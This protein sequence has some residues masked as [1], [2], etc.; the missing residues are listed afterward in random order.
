MFEADC[1]QKCSGL[2]NFLTCSWGV[3]SPSGSGLGYVTCF[4]QCNISKCDRRKDLKRNCAF[5][6]FPFAAVENSV[7][8]T[9]CASPTATVPAA[10]TL[11]KKEKQ[12]HNPIQPQPK[13]P[14]PEGQP[15]QS[16]S[17]E[18]INECCFKL[19][20]FGVFCY[21]AWANW[22][23]GYPASGSLQSALYK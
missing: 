16:E 9:M 11:N 21:V 12:F 17:W 7:T 19:L 5:G 8:T 20:S 6:L 13:W 22:Y 2:N 14:R 4:D 23:N 3:L 18:I 1:L 15:H 10:V